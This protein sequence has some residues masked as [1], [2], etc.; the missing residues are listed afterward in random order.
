[1]SHHLVYGNH[2]A[3]WRTQVC[4]TRLHA[5]VRRLLAKIRDANRMHRDHQHLMELS[6]EMLADIGLTRRDIDPHHHRR[7]SPQIG[8]YGGFL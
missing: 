3:R 4:I 5:L 8:G 7:S 6:D 2:L 1:M